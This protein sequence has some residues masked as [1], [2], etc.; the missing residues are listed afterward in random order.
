MTKEAVLEAAR[1]YI[2]PAHLA[3]V[4]VGDRKQ[5]EAPLRATGIGSLVLLDTDG[6][7]VNDSS[8]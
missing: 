3:I 7:P 4:I 6:N 5:I 2:D 1:R 8:R